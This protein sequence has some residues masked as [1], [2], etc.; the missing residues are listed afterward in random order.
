MWTW[1]KRGH[2]ERKGQKRNG[3]RD[4]RDAGTQMETR[5]RHGPERDW[6][7]GQGGAQAQRWRQS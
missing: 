4:K 7:W 3:E 5:M 1:M 6:R 2:R